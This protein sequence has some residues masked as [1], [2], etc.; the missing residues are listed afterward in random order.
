[1]KIAKV[2]RIIERLIAALDDADSPSHIVSAP[3]WPP[4]GPDTHSQLSG[5]QYK[6]SARAVSAMMPFRLESSNPNKVFADNDWKIYVV[7]LPRINAF[8]LPTRE[9]VIYTGLIDLLEDDRLLSAVLSHE[10]AHVTQRHAVENFMKL[11]EIAF[12]I[13]RGISVTDAAG[14][15]LNLLNDH[16][17]PRAYSRKLEIE[18]DAIGLEYMAKAGYDPQFA[19]DLWDVMA[20]VEEDAAAS[21]QAISIQ[22]RMTLLRTHPTSLQRQKNIQS[23][24]PKAMELYRASLLNPSKRSPAPLAELGGAMPQPEL[25][26]SQ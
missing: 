5:V 8:A 22:D 1:M 10:I 18:A 6:P 3:A 7:D 20:A 9:I 24:L 26:A 12:D 4:R 2:K 17:A 13:L 21:G 25:T 14:S 23:I 16:A 19:I 11:A 15:F